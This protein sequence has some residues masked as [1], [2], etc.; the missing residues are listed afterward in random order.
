MRDITRRGFLRGTLQ[1]AAISVGLP[2]L[3]CLLDGSGKAFAASGKRLPVIWYLG[4]GL[5]IYS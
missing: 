5:R 1:G 3:D 4:M 2:F